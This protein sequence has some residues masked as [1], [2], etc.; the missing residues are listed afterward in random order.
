[1][2]NDRDSLSEFDQDFV[3]PVGQEQAKEEQAPEPEMVPKDR[4]DAVIAQ[5]DQAYSQR[6]EA[7]R[8]LL[9]TSAQQGYSPRNQTP[10]APELQLPPDLDE[11]AASQLKSI[12]DPALRSAVEM[13]RAQGAQDAIQ[14]MENRYGNALR[15]AQKDAATDDLD[16]RVEGFTDL[17]GEVAQMFN[18]LNQEDRERYDNPAGIEAL[19]LRVK[20]RR[21]QS[22]DFSGMAHSVPRGAAPARSGRGEDEIWKMSDE[23]FEAK[24][25]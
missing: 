20:L 15:H 18:E 5:R 24:Y 17:R 3:D 7:I 23:E 9:S 6:E 14:A 13:A 4:L 11:D 10:V 8:N 21:A 19:A 2:R 12:I 25:G 22:G 16:A 1:M